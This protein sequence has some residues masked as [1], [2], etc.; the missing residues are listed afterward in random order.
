MERLYKTQ[1]SVNGR[2]TTYEVVFENELYV[3]YPQKTDE[4][5]TFSIKREEDQWHPQSQLEEAL[6]EEAIASLES[7]L[8]SQ[9]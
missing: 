4:A 7:Y 1:L 2:Q 8:L 5:Q 3:F 6:Q 9:H